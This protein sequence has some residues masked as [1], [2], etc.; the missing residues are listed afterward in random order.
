MSTNVIKKPED[1]VLFP[2]SLALL[3]KQQQQQNDNNGQQEHE[4]QKTHSLLILS[5]LLQQ[6]SITNLEH[7]KNDSFILSSLPIRRTFW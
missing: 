1:P 5:A 7:A 2:S 6:G 3:Q 4:Q